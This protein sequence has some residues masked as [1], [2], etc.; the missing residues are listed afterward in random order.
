MDL[1]KIHALRGPN[2][3]S[4]V[5]VLEAR[6][7][8]AAWLHLRVEDV[9]AFQQRLAAW[10]PGSSLQ[11]SARE[12]SDEGPAVALAQALLEVTLALQTQVHT[13]VTAGAVG[14]VLAPGTLDVAV[15]YEEETLGRAC[16]ASAKHLCVK[17]LAAQD[18]DV[19]A[20]IQRLRTLAEDVCLGRAT[21]P[22]VAAARA[23]GI[24]FR[25][26]DDQSLVQL[27]QGRKQHRIRTSVTDR[28]GKIAEWISLDKDLTKKLLEEVGLPV[29]VGRPVVSAEHAWA[30][31]CD[32]GL[33]VAIKPRSADYGHGIGLNL[34]TCEQVFAAYAAA[35]EY[36]EE[37]LVECFARGNQYRLT[38]VGNRVVAAVRREPVSLVGDGTHTV[39]QLMDQAN[40]D[41]RRGDDLR[42]PLERVCADDD[43]PQVLAEQGF[44]VES[45]VPAGVSLVLSRIAHSWAGAGVSDVTDQVHPHVAAQAVRA[46]RLIGLDVAGLDV[47][48]LDIGRPLEDQ[49][50]VIL[51]VNAEPTIAFHFPPLCD[52]YRPVCEAIVASLFPQGD[53]GR[54]PVTVVS[55]CG[56]RAGAGRWLAELL[57][58]SRGGIGRASHEG[59]FLDQE[60]LKSGD[61][62]NLAGTLALLLCP[63]IDSAI[64]ERSLT[65]IRHD[66][67]GLD[68]VEATILTRLGTGGET[69]LDI[70]SER[71]ARALVAATAPDGVVV[72]EAND[73]AAA[74]LV[75][76]F[77][78]TVVVVFG[79][80]LLGAGGGRRHAAVGL[81]DDQVVVAA[82]DGRE[83]ILARISTVPDATL[84]SGLLA[85]VAAAWAMGVPVDTLGMRME[86]ALRERAG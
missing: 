33:P 20:E 16:L 65:G 42:L 15:A 5:S 32:L 11:D 43:T 26:L 56:D 62:A 40:L 44:G 37:I 70:E 21:G 25:R 24:P 53:T 75:K 59:L 69:S 64:L 27:G 35:R 60:P 55:G 76:S 81:R 71:A 77:A 79:T 34:S 52:R 8:V 86:L 3:W 74:E 67:L 61:Q 38:V 17:A 14:P 18:L 13:P 57:H 49:G 12:S 6:I 50:G 82:A 2:V 10:L 45:I 41:P 46:A 9:R 63:E 47:V 36:G 83:Q 4:K 7:D 30:T 51:E 80:G 29:P 68:V 23:K 48:A 1:L 66:G 22:L 31:A 85:A 72:I 19:A 84:P 39:A 73:P 28:T 58:D 54:I 78:G